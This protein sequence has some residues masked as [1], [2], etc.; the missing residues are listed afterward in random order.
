MKKGGVL[1]VEAPDTEK[2]VSAY[3]ARDEDFFIDMLNKNELYEY[4]KTLQL[5]DIFVGLLS[6]YI[7]GNKHVHVKISKKLVNEYVETMSPSEFAK[8]CISYQ[9]QNQIQ[10]GGHINPIYYKKLKIYLNI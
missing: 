10:S 2:I 9:S 8:W 1:R 7:E 3:K 5:H 4:G 6:C